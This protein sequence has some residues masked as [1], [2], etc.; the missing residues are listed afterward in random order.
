MELPGMLA[1]R[2]AFGQTQGMRSVQTGDIVID[3]VV[4]AF[5]LKGILVELAKEIFVPKTVREE[6]S[7]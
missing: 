5:A 2:G 4:S 6:G 7:A 3:A 1:K